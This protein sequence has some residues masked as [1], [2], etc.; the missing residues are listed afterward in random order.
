MP[1]NVPFFRGAQRGGTATRAMP[2]KQALFEGVIQRQ[3][4]KIDDRSLYVMSRRHWPF[5][6]IPARRRPLVE[7]GIATRTAIKT[8]ALITE[9]P[10]GQQGTRPTSDARPLRG[11][12]PARTPGPPARPSP[13]PVAV[14][15]D[16][17]HSCA[18]IRLSD[19]HISEN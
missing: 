13:A 2:E 7:A 4:A 17:T 9:S 14:A 19:P 11:G 5:I 16:P 8:G 18:E 12:I 1:S 15:K 10:L 6:H 3:G